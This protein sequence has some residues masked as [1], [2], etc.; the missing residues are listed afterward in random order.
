M[1]VYS[2]VKEH[3]GVL[4]H[5]PLQQLL[6]PKNDTLFETFSKKFFWAQVKPPESKKSRREI[7][8]GKYPY[9]CLC[10]F[11]DKMVSWSKRRKQKKTHYLSIVS[12]VGNYKL[13]CDFKGLYGKSHIDLLQIG[14][15]L[16]IFGD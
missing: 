7:H 15:R 13:L 8:S 5:N 10:I 9:I 16:V 14:E 2:I 11:T 1:N 3:R 6:R 12:L 4:P